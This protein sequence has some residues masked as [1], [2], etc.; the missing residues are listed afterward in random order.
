MRDMAITYSSH[1]GI[2]ASRRGPPVVASAGG[3][4]PAGVH[5]PRRKVES[6]VVLV[7]ASDRSWAQ[8]PHLN[9][10]WK[11]WLHVRTTCAGEYESELLQSRRGRLMCT[12]LECIGTVRIEIVTPSYIT[13]RKQVGAD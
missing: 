13:S 11:K 9:A 6:D 12:T 4:S 10:E 8:P 2:S 7:W 3:A 1:L 5:K